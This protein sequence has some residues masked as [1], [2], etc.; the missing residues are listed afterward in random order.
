MQLKPITTIVILFLVV[1]SLLVAGCTVNLGNPSP[2]ATPTS[3]YTP[4][5]TPTS[6]VST[7]TTV[8]NRITNYLKDD[9]PELI[10]VTPF[11]FKGLVN[12]SYLYTGVIQD[13]SSKLKVWNRTITYT[14]SDTREQARAVFE[15]AKATA[16]SQGYGNPI[17]SD[18]Y[19]IGVIGSWADSV[20]SQKVAIHICQ[21]SYLCGEDYWIRVSDQYCVATEYMTR[22]V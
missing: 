10:I 15:K 3:K 18:T 21:P 12:G 8:A 17:S 5:Y 6:S 20:G 7:P 4:S 1:A 2:T 19:W 9:Y 22:Q 11:A 13:G 14:M 16:I